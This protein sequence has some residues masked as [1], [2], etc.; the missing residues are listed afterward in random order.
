MAE[1]ILVS[2]LILVGVVSG[3][4]WFLSVIA[5]GLERSATGSSDGNSSLIFGLVA[6][7]CIGGAAAFIFT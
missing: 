3:A 1:V 4:A 7:V 2:L 6:L 5:T